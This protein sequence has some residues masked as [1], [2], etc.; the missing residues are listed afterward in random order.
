MQDDFLLVVGDRFWKFAV[1]RPAI[2]AS[3]LRSL[4]N[5]ATGVDIPPGRS[6]LVIGQ[7]VSDEDVAE[8]LTMAPHA[9]HANRFDFSRWSQY[10][11]RA[12]SYASHKLRAENILL[13]EARQVSEHVFE[14]SLMLDDRCELMIDHQSGRH[15][16]GVVL[17]EAVRQSL[18]VVTE[19]FYLPRDGKKHDFT[20]HDLSVNFSR[21]CFP[22]ETRVRYSVRERELRG[23]R[24]RFAVDIVLEQC[25]AEVVSATAKMTAHLSTV[26]AKV[27]SEQ[28]TKTLDRHLA[29][30]ATATTVVTRNDEEALVE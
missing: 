2:T 4:L 14:M 18:L 8:L 30:L 26:L 6:V 9:P 11:R 23:H 27:E 28:A 10:P 7:G 5:S 12:S 16:S 13:S 29:A 3:Y 25:G 1:D 17:I 19:S 20:F 22:F 21:Y 24:C 15:L